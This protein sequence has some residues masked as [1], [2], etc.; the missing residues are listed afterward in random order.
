[1]NVIIVADHICGSQEMFPSCSCW[2]GKLKI[3]IYKL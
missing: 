2:F 3:K 1:M